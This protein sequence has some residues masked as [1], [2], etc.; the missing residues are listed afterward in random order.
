MPK[1]CAQKAALERECRLVLI[2][3]RALDRG[4]APGWWPA[5]TCHHEALTIGH[6]IRVQYTALR[7]RCAP[8]ELLILYFR[9]GSCRCQFSRV[10]SDEEFQLHVQ[11]WDLHT[12]DERW[13][14][15]AGTATASL[16]RR[17]YFKS[18][19]ES[20]AWAFREALRRER[21]NRKRMALAEA[22]RVQN[23]AECVLC[24]R[25]RT[26]PAGER[27]PDDSDEW[28][29]SQWCRWVYK[30]PSD[31]AGPPDDYLSA[32]T[33]QDAEPATGSA[34]E[35][36]DDDETD[37]DDRNEEPVAATRPFGAPP[38]HSSVPPDSWYCLLI[39]RLLQDESFW[40]SPLERVR[41]APSAEEEAARA[42]LSFDTIPDELGIEEL[43]KDEY[44]G[45]L[46]L[47]SVVP[48]SPP[49]ADVLAFDA[50]YAGIGAWVV[51]A[52]DY[53][54]DRAKPGESFSPLELNAAYDYDSAKLET[55]SANLHPASHGR[56][57]TA[58]H[59]DNERLLYE[60]RR[61]V[62]LRLGS[63]PCND[64]AASTAIAHA[65]AG[66]ATLRHVG[67]NAALLR[68]QAQL[69]I[70]SRTVLACLELGARVFGSTQLKI[71]LRTLE[72]AGYMYRLFRLNA[73]DCG[74]LQGRIRY[75]LV[76]MLTR[77]ARRGCDNRFNG[78]NAAKVLECVGNELTTA[79]GLE[80]RH[81]LADQLEEE[82]KP[83][84]EEE[85]KP[86]DASEDP[87]TMERSEFAGL[88][89]LMRS[90]E[91]LFMPTCVD[92][93]DDSALSSMKRRKRSYDD[94]TRDSHEDAMR[95]F[96]GAGR[97]L[98]FIHI[99]SV[100]LPTVTTSM[101]IKSAET[102]SHQLLLQDPRWRDFG[103]NGKHV[104]RTVFPH[105]LTPRQRTYLAYS[106][107][108]WPSEK[109]RWPKSISDSNATTYANSVSRWL[110]ES[111][112]IPWAFAILRA[113][114]DAG[115]FDWAADYQ[116]GDDGADGEAGIMKDLRSGGDR[117]FIA[118]Q[119]ARGRLGVSRVVAIEGRYGSQGIARAKGGV[120][121]SSQLMSHYRTG[122]RSSGRAAGHESSST[123]P[124]ATS[125]TE[126]PARRAETASRKQAYT[127]TVSRAPV[128]Y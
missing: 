69:I 121:V 6:P 34:N 104:A 96:V 58:D 126:P 53:N 64:C 38:L 86:R 108:C 98:P 91:F 35:E 51:A 103:A 49:R 106:M 107:F 48:L 95:P 47:A 101:L 5:L 41:V 87:G 59:R 114:R 28:F 83:R 52:D 4:F 50:D 66:G 16:S 117:V 102:A 78:A 3:A 33:G 46:T 71:A 100:P 26:L 125:R 27:A 92:K 119:K 109:R 30:T 29:C 9:P 127:R 90:A 20:V 68:K 70:S 55:L 22:A 94:T 18:A 76:A 1:R 118:Q 60:Q 12:S 11:P 14:E 56:A 10:L 42:R 73:A 39:R 31:E 37:D 123:T 24:R 21:A 111:I 43:A 67:A 110:G 36:F 79:N 57:V 23:W 72:L 89:G 74:G 65:E 2:N 128:A 54:A 116:L 105:K 85:W 44:K 61:R 81:S 25:W 99:A 124:T 82:W 19:R 62:A 113:L 40:I 17:A 8:S 75:A 80:N 115:A 93:P 77:R 32:G 120:T 84:T 97:Y 122:R 7:Q 13:I 15:G 45:A 112:C 88:R 63:N